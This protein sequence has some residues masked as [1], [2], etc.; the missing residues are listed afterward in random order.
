MAIRMLES[1]FLWQME[2]QAAMVNQSVTGVPE[3]L[4]FGRRCASDPFE[5]IKTLFDYL[6]RGALV[7]F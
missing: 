3:E 7:I 4:A 2:E 1:E 6:G 5:L